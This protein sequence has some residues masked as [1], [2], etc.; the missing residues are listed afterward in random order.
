VPTLASRKPRS[1]ASPVA[2][3]RIT[4]VASDRLCGGPRRFTPSSRVW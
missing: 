3:L 2:A 4:L 1:F